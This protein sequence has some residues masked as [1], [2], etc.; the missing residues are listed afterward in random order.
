MERTATTIGDDFAFAV[1]EVKRVGHD[2][3]GERYAVIAIVYKKK[4]NRSMNLVSSSASLPNASH[5]SDSQTD[6]FNDGQRG[7]DRG[8]ERQ[9]EA[10]GV[11]KP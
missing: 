8:G 7:E 10:F 1:D 5:G 3:V 2:A 9:V 4:R 6:R 11:R